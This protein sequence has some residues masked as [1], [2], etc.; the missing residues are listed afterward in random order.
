MTET[1]GGICLRGRTLAGRL[2]RPK[3][4]VLVGVG[5]GRINHRYGRG[6]SAKKNQLPP[7]IH[8]CVLLFSV[9]AIRRRATVSQDDGSGTVI[10]FRSR[11]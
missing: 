9:V 1:T 6:N 5:H 3:I 8:E 10:W 11:R 7:Q 2:I 4:D